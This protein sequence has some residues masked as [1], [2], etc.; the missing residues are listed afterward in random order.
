MSK[1]DNNTFNDAGKAALDAIAGYATDKVELLCILR[2]LHSTTLESVLED[3][4]L[5]EAANGTAH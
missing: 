5:M 2:A 1:L 4:A 3:I